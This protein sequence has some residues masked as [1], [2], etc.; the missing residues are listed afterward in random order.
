MSLRRVICIATE[1]AYEEADRDYSMDQHY[2]K[3]LKTELKIN[4]G[5][6]LPNIYDFKE[7]LSDF[8]CGESVAEARHG[9]LYLL[10]LE[11][12]YHDGLADRIQELAES[13][14]EYIIE[15]YGVEE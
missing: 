2:T 15:I 4:G 5:I 7:R 8:L 11:G 1:A 6:M 12:V 9:L 3:H 14:M 10:E 13:S